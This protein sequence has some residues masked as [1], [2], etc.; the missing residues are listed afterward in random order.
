M[1]SERF[2][3][4]AD[5]FTDAVAL[6]PEARAAFVAQVCASDEGLREEVDALLA[7]HASDS[8]ILDAPALEGAARDLAADLLTLRPGERV[9][10]YEVV[11]L[12]GA[13]GMGEVYE[14]LDDRLGR[15]VAVKVLPT[16]SA[17]DP[18]RLWRFE[19]E[20]RAAAALKHPNVVAVFDVGR[21]GSTRF[22]VSEL[23]EG[24]NLRQR[25]SGTPMPVRAAVQVV[26]QVA[27]GLAAAHAGG[28]VHR[29]LKPENVFL[30]RDGQVKSS[31]SGWPS[32]WPR[33]RWS[34]PPR[35]RARAARLASC[36]A[37]SRTW[38]PSR[39]GAKPWMRGPTSS[40]S[41]PCCTRC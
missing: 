40:P 39:C 11:R 29:D 32:S 12:I 25:M 31:T 35:R 23:L 15:R 34:T 18:H 10:P 27:R 26:S 6:P 19:Q 22:I 24:E 30:N 36:S 8:G 20:A 21:H 37:R 38:R 13:G 4:A 2:Q 3:R 5:I 33:T 17:N 28:V 7:A 9:G 1:P 16:W 41:A 14:A